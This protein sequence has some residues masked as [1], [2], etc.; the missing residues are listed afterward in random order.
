MVTLSHHVTVMYC[1]NEVVMLAKYLVTTGSSWTLVTTNAWLSQSAMLEKDSC[2]GRCYLSKPYY[3][4]TECFTC[5][6]CFELG[7]SRNC[8][9][10]IYLLKLQFCF[11]SDVYIYVCFHK[12]YRINIISS[13]PHSGS[14]QLWIVWWWPGVHERWLPSYGLH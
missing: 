14:P 8:S 5:T 2:G 3:P 11:H 7:Q 4:P 1:K 12:L 9:N 13:R 10:Q 6:T